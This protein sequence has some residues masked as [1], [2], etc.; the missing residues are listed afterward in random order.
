MQTNPAITQT[1]I[2]QEYKHTPI[3]PSSAKPVT[4][5]FAYLHPHKL[6]VQKSSNK[7]K[8]NNKSQILNQRFGQSILVE[9]KSRGQ[10][11][12]PEKPNTKPTTKIRSETTKS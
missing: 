12:E 2:Q 7:K 6:L 10:S 1:Q 5:Q 8:P 3:N 9:A 4:T 11:A